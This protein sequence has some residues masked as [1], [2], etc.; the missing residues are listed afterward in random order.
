MSDTYKAL[1]R[2]WRPLRFDEVVGQ[3]HISE[4]LKHSIANSRISHAY[5]FCGTRGT[6]KTSVAKIFARA[7]NCLNPQN[8]EPC[9]ECSSCIQAL[10]SS[11]VDISELDAASNNG[12]GNIR[13][14][15]G[16]VFYAPSSGKFRVY[17]IDEVHMLTTEAFNA[18][19]KTLEEPPSHVIFILATTEPHKIPA[20][21]LSRCQRFDFRRIGIPK[22]S[23]R[24]TEI[25][26]AEG[27]SI[28][29]DGVE[30]LAELADGS[31]RDGLSILEQCSAFSNGTLTYD[32]IVDIVGI[33]DLRILFD[34]SEAVIKGNSAAALTLSD[35]FLSAG[36][37]AQSFLEDLI[38]HFRNLLVCK[39]SDNPESLIEK[40]EEMVSR[41][42]NHAKECS[43]ELIIYCISVFSEYL[44]RSKLLSNPNIAVE[45]AIIKAAKPEYSASNDALL[46]RIEKLE[47]VIAGGNIVLPVKTETQTNL[48]SKST[49]VQSAN[50]SISDANK[51][52]NQN[53]GFYSLD[54]SGDVS[55]SV[56]SGTE[57]QWTLWS[58]ALPVIKNESKTLFAFLYSA[59]AL[60][61]GNRIEIILKSKVAY[62]KIATPNGI[63]Y[64][65]GL[66]SKINESP[67]G[68]SVL[69]EDDLNENSNGI[70]TSGSKGGRSIMDIAN[71]KNILGD[72]MNIIG[73]ENNNN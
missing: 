9:N 15:L 54:K 42:V 59:K 49:K 38:T 17:I 34:I 19:L 48:F 20:T 33:A 27:I 46:A 2:K 67:L 61:R 26:S 58:E 12:V 18:L 69:M 41:Y 5:L 35:K 51:Q 43:A 3:E 1:Y 4:T 64:L 45:T 21:I 25:I 52:E 29:P 31:M 66:F 36:K 44:S 47:R 32:D 50:N 62:E 72:K 73:G 30:L 14:I 16:E 55:D 57:K 39:S 63:K 71:K 6:G 56:E 11:F 22:I 7:V 53:E 10:S 23:K 40:N 13:D 24:I 37:E 8:G 70:N 60:D 65:S 68:V 28:T